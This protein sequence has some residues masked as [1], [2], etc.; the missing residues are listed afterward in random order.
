MTNPSTT[1]DRL[2]AVMCDHPTC[3]NPALE[4]LRVTHPRYAAEVVVSTPA[5]TG[6]TACLTGDEAAR[7]ALAL[8][9]VAGRAALETDEAAPL[10]GTTYIP[11][12]WDK[13]RAGRTSSWKHLP[14]CVRETLCHT[15]TE[16][17]SIAAGV[18]RAYEITGTNGVR[19]S[20]ETALSDLRAR[21]DTIRRLTAEIDTTRRDS[22]A[23]H[24]R[25]REALGKVGHLE[26]TIRRLTHERDEALANIKSVIET[27]RER[28]LDLE[29][30]VDSVV[31]RAY[32]AE[33]RL[34]ATEADLAERTEAADAL[35]VRLAAAQARADRTEDSLREVERLYQTIR[36]E[37]EALVARLKET[38]E[39]L[40]TALN[41]A[42]AATDA[43]D[44]PLVVMPGG[45]APERAKDLDAGYD[46]FA[47]AVINEA[48]RRVPLGGTTV[49]QV[50]PGRV[51]RI[52]TG[53]RVSI[54]AGHVGKVYARSGL[55][56]GEGVAPVNA[57]GIIDAG[58]TG[59]IIVPLTRHLA[60]GRALLRHGD[61]IA[62][63]VIEKIP[64]VTFRV[65]ND[66]EDTDRGDAGFGSTGTR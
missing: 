53:V 66:L 39:A 18:G 8:I 36:E 65:S 33:D 21:E 4:V 26:G 60:D 1:P 50:F 58:Y 35:G 14:E 57:V 34:K 59:E 63:L 48:G 22:A 51:T 16:A 40:A 45:K 3:E 37:R 15:I 17:N 62:Q 9:S 5:Y 55:A 43:V 49:G 41:G 13:N 42:P 28:I 44:V 38:G 27:M 10:S 56:S 2:F 32:Q 30:E 61:R 64:A 29:E 46:L 25:E 47:A 12:V 54:P 20:L 19:E 31:K 23:A 7:A 6:A 11:T 24:A 52:G